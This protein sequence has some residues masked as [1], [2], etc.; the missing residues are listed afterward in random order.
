MV[1]RHAIS[2]V[3]GAATGVFVRPFVVMAARALGPGPTRLRLIKLAHHLGP[4]T[5]VVDA[6]KR[7][8]EPTPPSVQPSQRAA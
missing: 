2:R 5:V 3:N 7:A 6:E 8:G 1:G 4:N